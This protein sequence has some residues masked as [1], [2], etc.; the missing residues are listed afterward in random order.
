MKEA[1]STPVWSWASV[2]ICS[3]ELGHR[4][5]WSGQSLISFWTSFLRNPRPKYTHGCFQCVLHPL[6]LACISYVSQ[7]SC[8]KAIV[9]P[10][11]VRGYEYTYCVRGGTKGRKFYYVCL[12]FHEAIDARMITAVRVLLMNGFVC[13]H[14]ITL[15][16]NHPFLFLQRSIMLEQCISYWRVQTVLFS[17]HE[18]GP[19][20]L[21]SDHKI[22]SVFACIYLI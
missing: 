6:V 2:K 15:I 12:C 8:N 5:L 19:L 1:F 16:A 10:T 3:G 20:H 4:F 21:S 17:C 7:Y 13:I 9:C 14:V 11:I 18:L 22:K